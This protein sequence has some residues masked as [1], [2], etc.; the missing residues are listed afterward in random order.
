MTLDE[1]LQTHDEVVRR[2]FDRQRELFSGD[3][4]PFVRRPESGTVTMLAPLTTEMIVLDVACGAAHASEVVAPHVRQVLGVDLT[5]S[6]LE[7]GAARLR[8]SGVVNVLLQEANAD[9]L[10]FVD[11]S[12]DVVF[13]M[14]SLHH[15]GDPRRVVA[16]MVRVCR[17]GGR[18]VLSD[19]VA[20]SAET[21]DEFDR[22]HRLIDPSHR[23]ALLASE[24]AALPPDG[25]AVTQ[26]GITTTRLPVDIAFTDQSERDAVLTT[27]RAEMSGDAATTTG[28]DPAEENGSLVVVFP[29]CT[30][31]AA[32]PGPEGV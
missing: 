31:T 29:A 32:R 14:S 17:P 13:C 16:E 8:D 27:L 19:L 2:S 12:F 24:L 20:P 25:L 9:A 3:D 15:V 5:T 26:G 22:V 4:S 11:G 30:V 1:Q 28:F 10:P 21:R 18:V 6:L 7:L 23:R